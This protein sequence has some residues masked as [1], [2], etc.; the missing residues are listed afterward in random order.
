TDQNPY[1]RGGI[2]LGMTG[3]VVEHNFPADGEYEIRGVNGT[4]F[5]DGVRATPNARIAMKAGVHKVGIGTAPNGFVESDTMLQS[6]TP[7]FS[8]G[9]GGFVSGGRGGPG[10]GASGR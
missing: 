7:G 4:L 9:G 3:T 5:I 2:P 8:N 1:V 10:G 6:F